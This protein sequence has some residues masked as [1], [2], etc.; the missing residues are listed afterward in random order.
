MTDMDSVAG[1]ALQ[2]RRSGGRAGHERSKLPP[3]RPWAQPRMRYGPTQ[4]LSADE[5]ESIHHASLRVLAELGMD[6]LDPDARN[7][8]KAAGAETSPDTQRVKFDPD[9]VTETIASAPPSFALHA[10]NPEHDL[11]I[12][13]DWMAFGTVGSP[14]NV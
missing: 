1:Q 2:R 3:Q 8:L 9:F 4:V 13:G 5:I 12:G 6:F 10:R 11:Q 14:P 7:R